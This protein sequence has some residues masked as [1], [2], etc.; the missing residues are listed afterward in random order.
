MGFKIGLD[1]SD[2]VEEFSL[3]KEDSDSLRT[4]VVSAVSKAIYREWVA[5][6]RRGL[7][8]T[9][10]SYVRGLKQF[11]SGKYANV[12]ILKG[13]FNN[14]LEDGTSSFDM[15]AGF[16]KSSKVKFNKKGGWYLTIPFRMGVPGTLG[17]SETFSQ[18]MPE[19]VYK[20]VKKLDKGGLSKSKIPN[21]YKLDQM[22]RW[23]PSAVINKTSGYKHKHSIYEGIQ[24]NVGDYEKTKQ[25]SYGSFRRVGAASNPGAFIHAGLKQGKFAD[26]ALQAVDVDM[27]VDN[28][29][30]DFLAR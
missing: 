24:K 14:M 9:R 17:E 12:I 1:I 6:A 25:N 22:S 21:M 28:T 8:S 4:E 20:A 26:K 15:K 27:V 19:E 7:H 2:V 16:R 5:A 30:D 23:N 3:S 13:V 29:V 10:Q 11:S 18:I